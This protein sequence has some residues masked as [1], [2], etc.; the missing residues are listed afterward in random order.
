MPDSI[1]LPSRDPIR[2]SRHMNVVYRRAVPEDV[3][4]CIDL[5]G[6]TRE[7]SIS[8]ERL[9]A[10]GVTLETW[11]REIAEGALPGYV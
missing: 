9:K 7:N 11:T 6:K 2:H 10:I 4:A 8:V 5:R 1:E 3:A